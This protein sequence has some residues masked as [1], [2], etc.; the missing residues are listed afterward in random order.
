MKYAMDRDN[1]NPIHQG[2][3]FLAIFSE[4]QP[5]EMTHLLHSKTAPIKNI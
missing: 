1:I 5:D 4:S 3:T 2:F